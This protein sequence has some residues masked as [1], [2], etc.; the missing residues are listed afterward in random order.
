MKLKKEK[1]GTLYEVIVTKKE[2][3]RMSDDKFCDFV[4]SFVEYVNGDIVEYINER[5]KDITSDS[6]SNVKNVATSV[7]QVANR[8][9]EDSKKDGGCTSSMCFDNVDIS[10]TALALIGMIRKYNEKRGRNIENDVDTTILVKKIQESVKE[11]ID[12]EIFE[13]EY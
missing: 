7:F 1:D 3:E 2:L 8:I 9:I 12:S 13:L 5:I 6:C 10:Y 4:I 11:L